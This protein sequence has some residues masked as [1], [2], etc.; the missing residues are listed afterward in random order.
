M[1]T[2]EINTSTPIETVALSDGKKLLGKI[3]WEGNRDETEKLIPA[4]TRL[5]KRHKKTFAGLDGVVAARGPGG[6]SA[7]RIGVTVANVLASSLKI[8]LFSYQTTDVS[9]RLKRQKIIAPEY[10]IAPNITKKKI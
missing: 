6:F 1:L 5:L 4:V 2:L 7:L 10:S 9:R 8:P 3:S